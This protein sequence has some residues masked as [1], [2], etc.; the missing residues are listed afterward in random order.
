[1]PAKPPFQPCVATEEIEAV[2][3]EPDLTGF[4]FSGCSASYDADQGCCQ[5]IDNECVAV[6]STEQAPVWV[7]APCTSNNGP[8]GNVG[9]AITT[10]P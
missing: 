2:L 10:A 6:N 5:R 8:G 1:M 3:A 4:V 9:S 7:T